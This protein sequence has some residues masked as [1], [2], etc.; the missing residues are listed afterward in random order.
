MPGIYGYIKQNQQDNLLANMTDKLY[1]HSHFVKDEEF[2]D[3]YFQ[4]SHVH[5]GKMK[6]DTKSFVKNGVYVSIGGEQYDYKESSFEELIFEA[7]S[8]GNLEEFLNKLDGYYNAVIYDSNK[9]KVF[10][11][12]DRYGMRMLYFYFKDG[13]FAFSSEVKGLLGLD[14][15]D[16][17]ID[18]AQIECFMDLGYL[19]EDNTWHKYIKLIKPASIIEFDINT[20]ELTQRY[21]WKWSEI[22]P[23]NISFDV[24]VDKLGELWL[25]AVGKRFNPT[26]KI[27]IALSGGLD[28]RAILAAVNKLYPDFKGYSFTFGIPKCDDIRIAKQC[29]A[30]TKWQHK[31][32]YFTSDN[33]FEPRKKKVWLTD[34]MMNMM[35]MHG[36]E[37]LDEVSANIDFSLNGYAGDVVLGGGWFAQLPTDTRATKRNLKSFYKQYIDICNIEDNFYDIQHVEPHLYMNRVR[38]FTNMG[39]VNGLY[40][41]DQRKPFFDNKLVEFIYSISDEY[42]KDNKLYSAML[43]KFFPKFYKDIPWQKTG[44][45][46]DKKISNSLMSKVIKKAKRIPYKLGILKNTNS[47]ADYKNWLKDSDVSKD[48]SNILEKQTSQYQKYTDID[49]KQKY[50]LPHLNGERDYSEEILRSVT[51]EIYLKEV[52]KK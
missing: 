39:T 9:Q 48:I 7:Y 13:H 49:F 15:V 25:E 10:L 31:K 42:R 50:L 24:A 21:Y 6:K 5:L 43:L 32:F 45:T 46:I 40:K 35:H 17:S 34:G 23:Q 37:F 8:N 11:I 36:S 3:D 51:I 4:A 47:Y 18:T 2:N 52:F 28:S 22:K 41:V 19:L 1:H 38:R 14:F 33:W 20:K 16:S 26:E 27:G 29:I 12:S 44:I 30:R